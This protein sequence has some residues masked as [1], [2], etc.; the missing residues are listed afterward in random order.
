MVCDWLDWCCV[1]LGW[2]EAYLANGLLVGDGVS[3]GCS[4][5]ARL[6][7]VADEG[8]ADGLDHEF[9]IVQGCDDD[10]GVGVADGSLDVGGRHFGGGGC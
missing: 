6:E 7:V 9:V 3:G 10:G 5:V 4:F 1:R 2:R 8:G